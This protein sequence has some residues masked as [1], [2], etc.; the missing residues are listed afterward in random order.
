MHMIRTAALVCFGCTCGALG[1]AG[2][3]SAS[4]CKPQ[5]AAPLL[6]VSAIIFILSF[7]KK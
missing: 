1:Q 6:I 3:Y 5:V 4:L 2:Y 7:D